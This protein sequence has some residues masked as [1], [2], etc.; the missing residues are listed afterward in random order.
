ML[1]VNLLTRIRIHRLTSLSIDIQ[2]HVPRDQASLAAI[3]T[4]LGIADAVTTASLE[5]FGVLLLEDGEV[6][7]G[8][9][10]PDGVGGEDEIH[11]FEAAL[12][13]FGV[14]GPDHYEC[15]GV[16]GTEEV[17]RLFVE[18]FEDCGEEQHLHV[19]ASRA[20]STCDAYYLQSSRY[21]LTNRPHPMHYHE[22]GL[23]MGRSQPGTAMGR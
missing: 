4:V 1:H 18:F 5:E 6:S 17:E 22:H 23:P 14:E 12:V 9:P 20:F 10:V 16:D 7:L 8:F 15:E 2:A 13:G 3:A 19:S 11:F 21:R